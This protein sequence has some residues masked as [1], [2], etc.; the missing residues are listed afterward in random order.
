MKLGSRHV[1][2]ATRP[3]C[4]HESLRSPAGQMM[5]VDRSRFCGVMI[6]AVA[7]GFAIS[8]WPW[9]LTAQYPAHPATS[10]AISAAD[11]SARDRAISDDSFQG[12]GPGTPAG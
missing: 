6:I 8:L 12:R 11:L 10:A 5:T 3:E 2:M 7:L 1:S 9:A 4:L